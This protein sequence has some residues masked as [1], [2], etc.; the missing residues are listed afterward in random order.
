M[1]KVRKPNISKH[2]L[3]L[4]CNYVLNLIRLNKFKLMAIRNFPSAAVHARITACVEVKTK[5]HTFLISISDEA[6]Y[7]FLT[8]VAFPH[9]P[10]NTKISEPQVFWTWWGKKLSL[11]LS[12]TEPRCPACKSVTLLNDIPNSFLVCTSK[13]SINQW[14]ELSQLAAR[15]RFIWTV[16]GLAGAP[17]NPSSLS[18]C[19]HCA[20]LLPWNRLESHRT[21]LA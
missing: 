5:L 4:I 21:N 6:R 15:L 3:N 16:R 2:N 14:I 18:V 1:D 13:N 20:G 10:L 12:G 19:R 8:P 7:H 17:N 11:S 9:S